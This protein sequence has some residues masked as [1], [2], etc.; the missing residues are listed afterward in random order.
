MIALDWQDMDLGTATLK[1]LSG[2]SG[3]TFHLLP[4][5]SQSGNEIAP[6]SY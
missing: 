4:S 1:I 6:V 2:T 3:E 5:C